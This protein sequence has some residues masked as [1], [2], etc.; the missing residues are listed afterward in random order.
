MLIF[1]IFKELMGEDACPQV[2]LFIDFLLFPHIF[3][4]SQENYH[5]IR[6][7]HNRQTSKDKSTKHKQWAPGPR[8]PPEKE[9]N[10]GTPAFRG[11][12]SPL[13]PPGSNCLFSS[14]AVFLSLGL[15]LA[16]RK[17]VVDAVDG[18]VISLSAHLRT[19][20]S[21]RGKLPPPKLES[22]VTNK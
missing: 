11:G 5:R 18:V 13:F 20:I 21:A 22:T 7:I 9:T 17:T 3:F 8:V 19:V 15:R 12:G 10:T 4:S 6:T 1:T 16:C 2:T 14:L